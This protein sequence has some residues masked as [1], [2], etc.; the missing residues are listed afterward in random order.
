MMICDKHGGKYQLQCLLCAFTNLSLESLASVCMSP[1]LC[2]H[3]RTLFCMIS[4][5]QRKN[6]KFASKKII[7]YLR[8]RNAYGRQI[9]IL[10][11]IEKLFG[12]T[13]EYCRLLLPK[14]YL[15]IGYFNI[16]CLVPCGHR[17]KKKPYL[18]T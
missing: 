15:I 6:W 12:L 2:L 18:S 16:Y 4:R 8:K 1:G 13:E 7:M 14:N 9:S 17:G 11:F 10:Y 5:K 3:L